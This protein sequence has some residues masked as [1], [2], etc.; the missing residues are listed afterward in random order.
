[1]EFPLRGG[2]IGSNRVGMPFFRKKSLETQRA[3]P[4]MLQFVTGDANR[5]VERAENFK[6]C[7]R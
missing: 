1:L 3:I 7:W 6:T 5:A 4:L 2:Y